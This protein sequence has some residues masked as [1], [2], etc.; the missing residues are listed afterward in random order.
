MVVT[1]IQTLKIGGIPCQIVNTSGE[2][3]GRGKE[4]GRGE[5][6]SEGKVG[7]EVTIFR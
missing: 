4:S 5:G 6:Y 7:E 1:H 3:R 2:R